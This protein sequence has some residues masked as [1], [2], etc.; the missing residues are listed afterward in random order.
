MDAAVA[1]D[2]EV[3]LGGR[4]VPHVDVHRG[5]DDDGGGG[6][7]VEGGE[8]VVGDALGEFCEGGGGGWGYDEGAGGLGLGYVLDGGVLVGGVAV[9]REHAGDD[10]VAGDGAEG[11]RGDELLG[12][13]GHDDVGVEAGVL[14]EAHEVYGLVGRDAAADS[15]GDFDGFLLLL[16]H[17]PL[18]LP[19]YLMLLRVWVVLPPPPLFCAK[20]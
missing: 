9:G 10:V 15:N 19:S 18:L 17:L 14:E 8:E 6:G 1:E 13:G 4:V 20:Y 3:G 2:G 7:E 5:G 11:E 12:G 16:V